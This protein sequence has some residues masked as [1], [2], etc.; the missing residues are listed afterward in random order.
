RL[1]AHL[2]ADANYQVSAK[3]SFAHVRSDFP[4]TVAGLLSEGEVSGT[5]G[6]GKCEMRLT[7]NNGS[8]E[9]LKTAQ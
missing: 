3:T 5:L 4:L 2:P 6:S 7:N 1:R 9:I 8:I